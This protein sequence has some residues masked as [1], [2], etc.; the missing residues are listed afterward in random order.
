MENLSEQLNRIKELMLYEAFDEPSQERIIKKYVDQIITKRI[1][2]PFFYRFFKGKENETYIKFTESL[3]NKIKEGEYGNNFSEVQKNLKYL[4]QKRLGAVLAITEKFYEEKELPEEELNELKEKALMG[5]FCKDCTNR[6]Q[7][8]S[9]LDKIVKQKEEEKSSKKSKE[10]IN[11]K[12]IEKKKDKALR[13]LVKHGKKG[14]ELLA[15]WG[16]RPT[17]TLSIGDY[18][19]YIEIND[20]LK[21]KLKIVEEDNK[22]K[23]SYDEDDEILIFKATKQLKSNII[24][25]IDEKPIKNK[26]YKKI[27]VIQ[28]PIT[29]KTI[30]NTIGYF[31]IKVIKIVK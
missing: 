6:D 13:T 4:N 25:K 16:I 11:N 1:G 31:D 12:D 18:T 5:N 24:F 10:K 20:E 2:E 28:M 17:N 30:K 19:V 7:V 8:T 23:T 21:N 29:T 15:K 27:K 14:E 26:V 3:I 22:I 9:S